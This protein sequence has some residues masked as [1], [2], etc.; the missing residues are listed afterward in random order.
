MKHIAKSQAKKFANSP[1]CTGLEYD[2]ADPD[3]NSAL[4]IVNGR[5]PETGWVMNE[6]CKELVYVVS[7]KGSLHTR[8]QHQALEP[9]DCALIPNG[10]AY[11]FE[12]EA[13]TI[14]M[15]CTPAWYPEQHKE[16]A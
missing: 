12:G 4:G 7:G 8:S 1:T 15:P 16:I 13:L 9:G 11:Y 5:Y 3:I 10:E 6:V 14:L 2:L